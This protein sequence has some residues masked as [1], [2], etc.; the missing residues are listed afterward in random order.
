[1]FAEFEKIVKDIETNPAIQS[2][3]LISA[4]PGCFV[5][6][7]D[8]TMIEKCKTAADATKLSH[9]GQLLFDRLENV[10]CMTISFLTFC[11]RGAFSKEKKIEN[12]LVDCVN[13]FSYRILEQKAHR[14]CNQWCMFGWWIGAG[15]RLSLSHRYER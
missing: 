5:A 7:A 12:Y 10:S 8:I 1:M 9:D 3:V 15:A 13:D 11:A 2:V 14:R 4:K 6:G